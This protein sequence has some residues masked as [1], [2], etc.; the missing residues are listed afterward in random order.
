MH[1][2]DNNNA[3]FHAWILFPISWFVKVFIQPVLG[4]LTSTV[5]YAMPYAQGTDNCMIATKIDYFWYCPIYGLTPHCFCTRQPTVNLQFARK[6][7]YIFKVPRIRSSLI[8]RWNHFLAKYIC[9]FYITRTLFISRQ[10]E[11]AIMGDT[12]NSSS[13]A[14]LYMADEDLGNDFHNL[15]KRLPPFCHRPGPLPSWQV[16]VIF[17]IEGIALCIVGS[18]GIVGNILTCAVLRR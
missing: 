3:C 17:W 11:Q 5:N 6:K 18:F 15:T 16:D 7:G 14:P 2:L 12:L 10:V 4:F 8:W 1:Y 9:K 13:S